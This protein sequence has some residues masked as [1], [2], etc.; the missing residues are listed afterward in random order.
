MVTVEDIDDSGQYFRV[1]GSVASEPV[2]WAPRGTG[3]GGN[4]YSGAGIL[5]GLPSGGEA[6]LLAESPSVP[7]FNG[8]VDDVENG[9]I[10]SQGTVIDHI[11]ED[12]KEYYGFDASD[13]GD[14][15]SDGR[16]M[17]LLSY[18]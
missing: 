13:F 12:Q 16:V 8:V 17:L 2:F 15:S 18:P 14:P 11:T 4:N 10:H 9:E 6:L 5:V 1:E 7:D 3:R